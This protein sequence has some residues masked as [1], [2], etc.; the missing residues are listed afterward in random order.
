MAVRVNRAASAELR[1]AYDWYETERAGLGEAFL[2][3]FVRVVGRVEELP[4]FNPI[5]R[6]DVRRARLGRFPYSVFCSIERMAMT[7][8]S[9]PFITLGERPNSGRT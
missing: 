7:L 5:V 2:Q 6:W 3:E 4:R 8:S 9:W 1:Q